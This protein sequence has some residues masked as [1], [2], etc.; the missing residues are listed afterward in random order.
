MDLG[1]IYPEPIRRLAAFQKARELRSS[2]PNLLTWIAHSAIEAN[3]DA[4]AE[5]AGLELLALVAEARSV[6][7][8]KLDWKDKGRA[9]W[10]RARSV[11]SNETDAQELVE[12]ITGNANRKHWGHTVLGVLAARRD[13]LSRAKQH[14]RDSAAVGSDYRLSAY[15]P[16][17]LLAREL[18]ARGEWDAVTEYLLACQS[19]WNPEPL[20]QWIDQIRQQQVPEFPGR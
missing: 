10:T 11:C 17:F 14:L 9:L 8:E 4:A 13:D 19:F 16:S 12:A 7:G 18:C 15:G 5:Q 6:F 2:Q 3:A 1:R 20:R